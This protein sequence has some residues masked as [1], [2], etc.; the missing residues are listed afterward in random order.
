MPHL[1]SNPVGSHPNPTFSVPK[2]AHAI[3]GQVLVLGS[4]WGFPTPV[5]TASQISLPVDHW[6]HVCVP[7]LVYHF[8]HLQLAVPGLQL[9][10]LASVQNIATKL[11]TNRAVMTCLNMTSSFLCAL[12]K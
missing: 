2:A 3:T 1:G 4:H 6:Q 11:R 10:A 12:L 5:L 8:M 7:P 9:A